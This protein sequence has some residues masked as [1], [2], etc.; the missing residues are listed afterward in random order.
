MQD[1]NFDRPLETID[2]SA[3]EVEKL[4]HELNITK[5]MGPDNMHPFLLKKLSKTLCHPLGII[6]QKS[7]ST[8][9]IPKEW[10]YAKVTPLFKK[11]SSEIKRSVCTREKSEK[12]ERNIFMK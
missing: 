5:F 8:G 2:I 6:F 11:L 12:K 1:L 4:L 7:V 3:T 9:T 10:K